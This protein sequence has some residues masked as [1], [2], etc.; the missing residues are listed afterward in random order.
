MAAAEEPDVVGNEFGYF[1]V[2]V[3]RYRRLVACSRRLVVAAASKANVA[4]VQ[5]G[6]HHSPDRD[7]PHASELRE[8]V[9]E[10]VETALDSRRSVRRR[11]RRWT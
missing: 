3:V 8:R 4:Q 9:L 7:G 2:G 1:V 10:R 6:R 5:D 11:R